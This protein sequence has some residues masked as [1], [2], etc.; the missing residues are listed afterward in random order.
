MTMI[1][2][3]K[4]YVDLKI[5]FGAKWILHRALL[6]LLDFFHYFNMNTYKYFI[7]RGDLSAD[8]MP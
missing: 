4:Y 2:I 3:D 5:Y 8:N 7:N 6:R 1:G